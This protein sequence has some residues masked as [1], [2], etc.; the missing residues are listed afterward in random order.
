MSTKKWLESNN[1]HALFHNLMI[2]T[3]EDRDLYNRH[4]IILLQQYAR[5]CI[6]D[7]D[8]DTAVFRTDERHL[9]I[10]GWNYCRDQMLKN[11]KNE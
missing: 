10:R 3:Q 2:Y 9:E 11:I 8:F 4:L 5:S 1:E 6:P 7:K